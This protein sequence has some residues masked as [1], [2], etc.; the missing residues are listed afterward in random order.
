MEGFL[1]QFYSQNSIKQKTEF[2]YVPLTNKHIT[3]SR[4]TP[5]RE[6]HSLYVTSLQWP[7]VPKVFIR[8]PFVNVLWAS[9]KCTRA[10]VYHS[11]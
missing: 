8:I 3:S 11:I 6:T 4:S 5:Y 1:K 10:C 9:D 7:L 2:P